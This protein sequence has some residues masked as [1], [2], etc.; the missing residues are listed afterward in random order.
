MSEP[1]NVALVAEGPT[2]GIIIE[3]ALRSMLQGRRFVMTQLQPE[4]SVAFGYSRPGWGGVYRWCKQSAL[5]GGGRLAMDRLVLDRFDVL[6][7]HLDADVAA[8]TYA[9]AGIV[10]DSKDE[11]LPCELPC[12]PVSDTTN[13]LRDVLLTW[14]GERAAPPTVALCMPSK[15]TEAW[16]VASLYETDAAVTA[17]TPFECSENPG[18]RLTQQPKVQRIRK[19]QSDY[20]SQEA[21]LQAAWSSI[22]SADGLQEAHRFRSDFMLALQSSQDA[23]E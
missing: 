4:G 1:L 8:G 17:T 9:D 14:C 23:A 10:P 6:V 15:S 11:A 22:A 18:A 12:P 2:D 5:R 19:S 21:A 20:R 13:A 7:I 16:V 3:C